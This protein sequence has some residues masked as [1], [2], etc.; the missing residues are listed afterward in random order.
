M[1]VVLSIERVVENYSYVVL[2]SINV[3]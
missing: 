1:T 2:I 3:T